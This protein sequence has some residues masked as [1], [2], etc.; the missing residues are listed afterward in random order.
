V[1]HK[2]KPW[3]TS[4]RRERMGLSGGAWDTLRRRVLERDR[5]CC[6][7]CDKA[8][9]PATQVDHLIEV[10]NGGTNDLPSLASCHRSC[11][12]RRHREPEWAAERVQMA[13]RVLAGE[14]V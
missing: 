1:A 6:Y 8:G 3:A 13:L 7:L 14:V 11:H 5:G 2:P 10:A 12:E 4:K 9:P